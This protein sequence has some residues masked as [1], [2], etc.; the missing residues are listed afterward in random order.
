MK[1]PQIVFTNVNTAELLDTEDRNIS[2]NEVKVKT[3]ISTISPGTERANITGDLNVSIM[4]EEN[5][6]IEFPRYSGYSGAGI[7]IEIGKK[8]TSVKVGDRVTMYWSFHK[9]Y[10]ILPENNVVKIEYD[11]ISFEEAAKGCKKK[12]NITRI[13]TCSS[14]GGSGAAEGSAH[15]GHQLGDTE[16]FRDIV[17]GAHIQGRYFLRFLVAGRDDEHR[18]LIPLPELLQQGKAV[19]IGKAQIQ[20]YKIR[21]LGKKCC[22]GSFAVLGQNGLVAVL[23]QPL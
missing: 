20:Q 19:H 14:C 9:L 22:P 13:D 21:T 5:E 2:E 23:L 11:D 8:V 16:G 3:I 4:S 6:K 15:P 10:N 17:V 18:R 12:I 7:V 1:N